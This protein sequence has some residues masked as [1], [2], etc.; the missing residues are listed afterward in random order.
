ML[1]LDCPGSSE[2]SNRPALC[3]GLAE[4]DS[5]GLTGTAIEEGDGSATV[6]KG[7]KRPVAGVAMLQAKVHGRP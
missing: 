6:N 3:S 7:A 5:H 1:E 2:D 4:S